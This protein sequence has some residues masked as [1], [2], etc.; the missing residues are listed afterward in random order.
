[1]D[2]TLALGPRRHLYEMTKV[3]R[4]LVVWVRKSRP[5]LF[6]KFWM[7]KAMSFKGSLLDQRFH[8][9]IENLN[10]EFQLK[11]KLYLEVQKNRSRETWPDIKPNKP[12]AAANINT[13]KVVTAGPSLDSPNRTWMIKLMF[14]PHCAPHL[15]LKKEPPVYFKDKAQLIDP[16]WFYVITTML[17]G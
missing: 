3:L 2:Y 9:E 12:N 1:M 7:P 13:D 14:W 16:R 8:E 11:R 6:I 15:I 4:S 10:A 17:Q 5:S